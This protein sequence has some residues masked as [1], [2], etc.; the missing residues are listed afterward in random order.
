[1]I[2]TVVHTIYK[3]RDMSQTLKKNLTREWTMPVD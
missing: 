1:M 3:G 2:E